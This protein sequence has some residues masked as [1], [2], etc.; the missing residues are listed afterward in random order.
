MASSTNN[1]L[2]LLDYYIHEKTQL[3]IMKTLSLES[4]PY[5]DAHFHWYR[6]FIVKC[7]VQRPE[8]CVRAVLRLVCS[9][10]PVFQTT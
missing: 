7:T 2:P 3:E 9:L 10:S 8:G 5:V 1:K 4:G 6:T